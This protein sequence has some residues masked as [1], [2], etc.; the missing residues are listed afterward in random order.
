MT[1]ASRLSGF[2]LAASLL[3]LVPAAG[4]AQRLELPDAFQPGKPFPAIA[5]PTLD[6]GTPSSITEFRGERLIVHVFASW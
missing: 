3:T 1:R 4:A 5:F 6:D 2:L